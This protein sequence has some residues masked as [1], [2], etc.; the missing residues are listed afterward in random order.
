M[1]ISPAAWPGGHVQS[2]GTFLLGLH[3]KFFKDG[4]IKYVKIGVIL[5]KL[6]G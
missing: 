3:G 4:G 2:K 5:E 1:L 6:L